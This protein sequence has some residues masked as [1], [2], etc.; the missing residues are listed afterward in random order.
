MRFVSNMMKKLLM[1]LQVTERGARPKCT[2]SM[3]IT[4]T[5]FQEQIAPALREFMCNNHTDLND[6]VDFVCNVFD[7]DAT[8]ELIDFVADEF[9]SFFGN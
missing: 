3:N 5:N 1:I 2:S 6:A 9:D 8:D 4:E 7:L